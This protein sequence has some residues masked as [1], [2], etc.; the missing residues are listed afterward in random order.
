MILNSLAL[1]HYYSPAG[2]N[3]NSVEI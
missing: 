3:T 2:S 1:R